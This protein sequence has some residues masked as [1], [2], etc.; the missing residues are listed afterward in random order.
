MAVGIQKVQDGKSFFGMQHSVIE[1]HDNLLGR[2]VV[3]VYKEPWD[4]VNAHKKG[5]IKRAQQAYWNEPNKFVMFV[6]CKKSECG[7]CS[8]PIYSDIDPCKTCT[9]GGDK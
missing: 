3:S 2:S 6:K 4:Q 1:L 7:L 5:Y 9:E 8:R